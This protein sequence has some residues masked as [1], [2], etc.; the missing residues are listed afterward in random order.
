MQTH[1]E[2]PGRADPLARNVPQLH[3]ERMLVLRG[4]HPRPGMDPEDPELEVANGR[5]PH[6]RVTALPQRVESQREIRAPPAHR[7]E[8]LPRK[9]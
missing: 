2:L 7:I 1:Q 6:I 9:P 3:H 8:R 5:P 4:D